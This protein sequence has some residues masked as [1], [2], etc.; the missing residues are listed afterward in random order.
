MSDG[1]WQ[2]GAMGPERCVGPLTRTDF[3]RYAGA[4]GDFNPIHHDEAF[5]QAAGFASVFGHG[6]LTA[7][8]LGGY[9]ADWLDRDCLRH[10][11]VRYVAQVWPGDVLLLGGR[12]TR[13][14]QGIEGQMVECT[15]EVHR[16]PEGGET[17]LVLT[18]TA[19]ALI[20]GYAA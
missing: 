12:V 1:H 11:A 3:V 15:L 9:V 8:I 4:S 7:G 19:R 14:E 13:A 2:V 20:A 18:G 5:A 16:R 17:Q 6:L 10:F